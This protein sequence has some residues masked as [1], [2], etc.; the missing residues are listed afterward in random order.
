LGQP[1]A[2]EIRG[3]ANATG[4][5]LGEM[6][7]C[8][9]FY[10]LNSGCTSTV[11]MHDDGTILHGR[12]LDYSIPGLQNITIQANFTRNGALVYRTTTYA[13]YVGALT[14]MKPGVL[15]VSLDQ[16]HTNA[17]LWDNIREA[18]FR[19]GNSVG[20]TLRSVL[21]TN[22]SFEDA[23]SFL[24]TVDLI[25][26]EYIIVGGV[27][28]EQGAVITRERE[29][30]IDVWRIQYPRRWFLVETNYD[31]WKPVPSSDDRRDPANA[32]LN[33]YSPS[34][35]STAAFEQMLNTYP[36]LNGMTTYTAVM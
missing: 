1:W 21:E 9:L 7:L 14:G 12:N 16:R 24:S 19:H 2:D 5:D 11:A 30:A 20:F 32:F 36:M 8:N 10:E 34:N 4:F 23:V 26:V 22:S 35:V 15:S 31:H 6:V 33:Q 13:G 25:S 3:V 18:L 17:T 28:A 29:D 27:S